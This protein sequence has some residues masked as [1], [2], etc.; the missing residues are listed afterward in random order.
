MRAFARSPTLHG[1]PL[2]ALG[3][4][5]KVGHVPAD[6]T[7]KQGLSSRGERP[8]ATKRFPSGSSMLAMET[9]ELSVALCCTIRKLFHQYQRRSLCHG[10]GDGS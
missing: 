9:N 1:P 6:F 2:R 5:D 10:E 7:D 8:P 4:P 3:L